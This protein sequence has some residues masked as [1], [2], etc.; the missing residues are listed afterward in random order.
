M[1]AFKTAGGSWRVNATGDL[2]NSTALLSAR[3]GSGCDFT[4]RGVVQVPIVGDVAE[5]AVPTALCIVDV[6]R[7]N[8][9][10]SKERRLERERK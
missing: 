7:E 4:Q 3:P 5:P 9:R 8:V 6:L 10:V 1:V 2:P